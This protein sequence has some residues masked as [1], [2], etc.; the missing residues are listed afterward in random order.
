MD[1]SEIIKELKNKKENG[2]IDDKDY[3]AEIDHL[4]EMIDL[5]YDT[6][7]SVPDS[8]KKKAYDR[9]TKSIQRALKSIEKNNAELFDHLKRYC[10]LSDSE[11]CYTGIAEG[12]KWKLSQ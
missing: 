9:V 1:I 11:Y 6:N 12:V 3:D 2:E 10:K 4:N 7:R 5:A 8:N